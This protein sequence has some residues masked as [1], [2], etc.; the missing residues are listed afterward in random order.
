VCLSDR[1]IRD[2][3]LREKHAFPVS[4]T[5]WKETLRDAKGD[6]TAFSRSHAVRENGQ[7]P[8]RGA[9]P[10]RGKSKLPRSVR[11]PDDL[12]MTTANSGQS[13]YVSCVYSILDAIDPQDVEDVLNSDPNK[14]DEVRRFFEVVDFEVP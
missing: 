14:E 13:M 9:S 5:A 1:Q 3:W 2:Q 11:E 10:Q 8:R 7:A 6:L 12:E 4:A